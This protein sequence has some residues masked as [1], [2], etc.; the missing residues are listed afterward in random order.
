MSRLPALSIRGTSERDQL[1]TPSYAQTSPITAGRVI[2][3]AAS[4][5]Q[6]KLDQAFIQPTSLCLLQPEIASLIRRPDIIDKALQPVVCL[7]AFNHTLGLNYFR[8][9]NQILDLVSDCFTIT[10]Y[11]RGALMMSKLNA[12]FG[13][14]RAYLSSSLLVTQLKDATESQLD[15]VV[16]MSSNLASS[17][18]V[19]TGGNKRTIAASEPNS[20]S[21]T[22]MERRM[23]LYLASLFVRPSGHSNRL[24]SLNLTA[25]LHDNFQ[26]CTSKLWDT[27]AEEMKLSSVLLA[28]QTALT[29]S[30]Y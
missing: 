16:V 13:I 21:V 26:Q 22:G 7:I 30:V 14:I 8:R 4:I 17:L 6:T 23:Q 9:T 24:V 1:S 18:D 5:A 20:S 29:F 10:R 3:V 28:Y 25:T 19:M 2:E 11:L 15:D 27:P 12:R